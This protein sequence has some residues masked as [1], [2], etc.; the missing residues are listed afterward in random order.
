MNLYVFD[1]TQTTSTSDVTACNEYSWTLNGTTYTSSTFDSVVI[2][3]MYFAGT[4]SILCDSI[5]YLDLTINY[6]DTIIE[7]TIACDTYTWPLTGIT[8]TS[9]GTYTWDTINNFGCDSVHVL[10]LTIYSSDSTFDNVDACDSIY[11]M[12]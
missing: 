11:G 4:D 12:V 10:N 6:S 5:V 8:Y 1:S 9:G 7:D 3:T 2:P